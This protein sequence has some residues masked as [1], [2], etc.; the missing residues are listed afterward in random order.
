MI[1]GVDVSG[2]V[3]L[4]QE[5]QIPEIPLAGV[6]NVCNEQYVAR[7]CQAENCYYK[8]LKRLQAENER[9]KEINLQL[10][11]IDMEID[12]NNKYHKAL[13]EI[14]E[15]MQENCNQCFEIDNFTKPDDCGIC[16]WAR[17]LKVIS[18]VL[19]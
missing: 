5:P 1:D 13:E 15:I 8:Q 6:C 17:V 11:T 2:C 9:L 10:Q 14:R 12:R 4:T 19:E 16:E 3:Y 7:T 18:E